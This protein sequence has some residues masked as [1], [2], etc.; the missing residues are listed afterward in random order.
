MGN[1]FFI[2]FF[3]GLKGQG[4]VGRSWV[5]LGVEA[6]FCGFWWM[7]EGVAGGGDVGELIVTEL[8]KAEIQGARNVISNSFT[9]LDPESTLKTQTY[10]KSKVGDVEVT[11]YA[12]WFLSYKKCPSCEHTYLDLNSWLVRCMWYVDTPPCA[13]PPFAGA[14][15]T[16]RTSKGRT[17]MEL[18]QL[19]GWTEDWCGDGCGSP[20]SK[21]DVGGK[22][23]GNKLET[24]II[25]L[26]AHEMWKWKV[27][28]SYWR[29]V[30]RKLCMCCSC[31]CAYYCMRWWKLFTKLLCPKIGRVVFLPPSG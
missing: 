16:Q 28:D 13:A 11:E 9:Q 31:F 7:Q 20:C 25:K 6:R 18:A 8:Q 15:Y 27:Q 1:C 21:G 19:N 30:H 2:A 22:A 4:D 23:W 3:R 12:T 14:D 17:A 26:Y 5:R 29:T 24:D 10:Q